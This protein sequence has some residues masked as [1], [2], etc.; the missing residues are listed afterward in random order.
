MRIRDISSLEEKSD[1]LVIAIVK[2]MI[3]AF[4]FPSQLISFLTE[5]DDH[6][7]ADIIALNSIKERTRERFQSSKHL[8]PLW[9]YL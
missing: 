9:P 7:M 3:R 8:N 1:T 5:W 6:V 4:S 2:E